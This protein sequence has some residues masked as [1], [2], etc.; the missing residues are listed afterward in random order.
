MAQG[1]TWRELFS[2]R[3][4][5]GPRVGTLSDDDVPLSREEARARIR[6]I[7]RGVYRD[8]PDRRIV[9]VN[10]GAVLGK[11]EIDVAGVEEGLRAKYEMEL[12]AHR[13]TTAALLA[14]KDRTIAKL[15]DLVG[16]LRRQLD[17]TGQRVE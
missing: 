6:E 1:T 11:D 13:D 14:E 7:R 12:A 10:P 4:V 9:D 2:N 8:R 15:E 17:H 3:A 16:E 5:F